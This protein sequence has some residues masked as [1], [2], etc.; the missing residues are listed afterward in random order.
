MAITSPVLGF[1]TSNHL[2]LLITPLQTYLAHLQFTEAQQATS[3]AL[4]LAESIPMASPW[5]GTRTL[6]GNFFGNNGLI[7]LK[8]NLRGKFPNDVIL[9]V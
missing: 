4:L 3:K 1:L 6:F 8:K 2:A 5:L 7:C 9:N